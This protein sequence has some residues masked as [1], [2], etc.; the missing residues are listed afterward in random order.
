MGARAFFIFLPFISV[1]RSFISFRL[2]QIAPP[3]RS[4]PQLQES[5]EDLLAKDEWLSP[6]HFFEVGDAVVADGLAAV[7]GTDRSAAAARRV[8]D[9]VLICFYG[10]YGRGRG[11][12]SD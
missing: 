12:P 2:P 1:T 6:S 11:L 10:A 4:H 3:P 8:M 9:A 5:V 7:A